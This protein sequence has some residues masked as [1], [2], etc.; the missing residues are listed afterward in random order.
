MAI[1]L[2]SKLE[3]GRRWRW[4][5]QPLQS[6]FNK[7]SGVCRILMNRSQHHLSSLYIIGVDN[8]I[9][10]PPLRKSDETPALTGIPIN[11]V[12]MN[13]RALI[14]GEQSIHVRTGEAEGAPLAAV[15]SY[16]S[17]NDPRPPRVQ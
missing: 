12:G 14:T 16:S 11:T 15:G 17:E 6:T 2:Y 5:G 13:K 1:F 4:E 7:T 10:T 8:K 3:V 9:S